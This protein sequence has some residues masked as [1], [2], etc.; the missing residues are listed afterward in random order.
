MVLS[1][2]ERL[3]KVPLLSSWETCRFLYLEE[4]SAIP[5]YKATMKSWVEALSTNKLVSN[6]Y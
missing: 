3:L 2:Q 1:L 6:F 4:S 5:P